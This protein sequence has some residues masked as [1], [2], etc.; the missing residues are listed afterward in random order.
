MAFHYE[1]SLERDITRIR[2]KV[3]EM[4]ALAT[5]ALSAGIRA[6]CTRNRQMAYTVILRDRRIDE[7]EKEVDRLCLEFLVRQQPVA[8]HL[9]FAYTTIKVNLELERIGDYAESIARQ[10]IKL[11]AISASWPLERFQQLATLAIPM[12]SDVAKAF[13][14]GD[15]QLARDVI[16]RE[17][18]TDA[19]RS[20]I[21]ADLFLLRHEGKL[22]Q[23]ALNPLLTIARRFE[24]AADQATNIAEEVIYMA[25]G[26]YQKHL[27]GDT[28]RMVFIDEHNHCRS[29]LAEA[30]GH[31]LDQ[32][33]FVFFSAGLDPKPID[34][35]T[36][37]FL[38]SKGLQPA[39][40]HS[41]SVGQLPN[42]DAA[43]I[44]VALN[45]TAKRAFPKPTKAVC[46][47]WSLE[48]PSAIADPA[49]RAAAFEHAYQFLH[50]H[51]SELCEA[52]LGDKID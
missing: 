32:P 41:K 8:R 30:I 22:P 27:G 28:W 48:D 15:H 10:V 9:R 39:H 31:S 29:Q 34:P 46:L 16:S 52:V 47:D 23:E 40:P 4:A 24:R 2:G 38:Q 1:E 3:S 14:T 7:L 5:E 44:I 50:Q 45:P 36:L 37:E 19:L 21:N 13:V 20:Q 42:L 35:S 33:N 49:Q 51:I 12:I 43:Q 25:T 17:A 11:S 26:E 18:E 6:L